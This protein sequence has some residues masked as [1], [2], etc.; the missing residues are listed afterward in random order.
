MA[1]DGAV[2]VRC[3]KCKVKFRDKAARVQSG[4]S[5]ECPHCEAVIFFEAG[6]PDLDI[7]NALPE[8]ERIRRVLK[9]EG[10]A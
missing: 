1:T 6:S 8:A 4:Y 10:S 9:G 7:R 2:Q 3:P 5:R